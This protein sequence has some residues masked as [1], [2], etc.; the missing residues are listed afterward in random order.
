[1]K[2]LKAYAIVNATTNLDSFKKII[3]SFDALSLIYETQAESAISAFNHNSFDLLII[4]K[5]LPHEDYN[6]LHKIADVLHP[7]AALVAFVMT[8]EEYIRYKLAGLMAKWMEAN[9]ERKTNFID[10]PKM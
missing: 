3:E 2:T 1:M 4:D 8:D 10:D 6:K 5:A 9:T 7:D